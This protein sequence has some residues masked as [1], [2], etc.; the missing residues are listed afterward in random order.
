[1]FRFFL[2]PNLNSAHRNAHTPMYIHAPNNPKRCPFYW[3]LG[4]APRISYL[5]PGFHFLTLA[6]HYLTLTF[7]CL[8]SH[9]F[10]LS[11]STTKKKTSS[12]ET[13]TNVMEKKLFRFIFINFF[14]FKFKAQ[15]LSIFQSVFIHSRGSVCDHSGPSA[16]TTLPTAYFSPVCTVTLS[17]DASVLVEWATAKSKPVI[18]KEQI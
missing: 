1:M 2:W 13:K 9:K 18:N 3:E 5:A 10:V 8:L 6:S 12:Q 16:H 17:G 4:Q 11:L 15:C 14:F 7:Y